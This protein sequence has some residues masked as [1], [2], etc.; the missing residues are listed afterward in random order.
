M[1]IPFLVHT[2]EWSGIYARRN[3]VLP[4]GSFPLVEV[5]VGWGQHNLVGIVIV[6]VWVGV[7][8]VLVSFACGWLL[9]VALQLRP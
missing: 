9:A 3:I 2:L 6:A 8:L 5:P 7:V 1:G 4:Q